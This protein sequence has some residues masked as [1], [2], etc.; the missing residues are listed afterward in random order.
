MRKG[1]PWVK[2]SGELNQPGGR[3]GYP[4]DK[5]EEY[6]SGRTTTPAA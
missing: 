4:E 5:L 2:L 6:L 1:P 3:V